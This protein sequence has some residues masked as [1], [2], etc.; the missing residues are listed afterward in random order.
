MKV[1][2][3][4]VKQFKDG[5]KS[6]INKGDILKIAVGFIMAQLFSK[7]VNSLCSDIIMPPINYFFYKTKDLSQMKFC[8]NESTFSI[9]YGIFI[10]NI[11]EFIMVSFFLYIILVF[12]FRKKEQT[13]SNIKQETKV[14][15]DSFKNLELLEKKQIEILNEIKEILRYKNTK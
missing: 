1:D 8:I 15:S 10:Q 6:F 11:F 13:D 3:K 4:K 5:F 12:I 2:L 9:N 14:Q 7:I